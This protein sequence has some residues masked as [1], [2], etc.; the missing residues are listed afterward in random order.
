MGVG[1]VFSGILSNGCLVLEGALR[2]LK[3]ELGTEVAIGTD[4]FTHAAE[5]ART[6]GFD[7]E[8]RDDTLVAR[9]QPG[10]ET[11]SASA[12]LNRALCVAGV[13]VYGIAVRERNLE[14][15]YRQA[16]QPATAA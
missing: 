11:R 13:R 12:A 7:V 4:N 10:E 5:V 6:H 16:G 15:L 8:L 3:A 14:T 1:I 2:D 9:L